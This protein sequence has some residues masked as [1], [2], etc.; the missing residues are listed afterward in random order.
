MAGVDCMGCLRVLAGVW[1]VSLY[2]TCSVQ[3]FRRI[4]KK[5]VSLLSFFILLSTFLIFLLVLGDFLLFSG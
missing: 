4:K 5:G 2:P 3:F 1:L